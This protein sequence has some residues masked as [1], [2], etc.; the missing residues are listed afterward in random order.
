[1]R[2]PEIGTVA[3][4]VEVLQAR[5][6]RHHNNSARSDGQVWTFSTPTR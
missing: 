2:E 1:M 5:Y 4:A 6:R 3:N